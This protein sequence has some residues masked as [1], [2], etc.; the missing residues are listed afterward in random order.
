[1]G[2][3]AKEVTTRG[4][5]TLVHAAIILDI[6]ENNSFETVEGPFAY[7]R[8][9]GFA[10]QIIDGKYIYEIK[11]FGGS[12][13]PITQLQKYL[14]VNADLVPG[15]FLLEGSLKIAHSQV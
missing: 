10:D 15:I 8:G 7:V 13:S 4:F 9:A 2:L 3:L 11:P 14:K 12:K 6:R 1:M 5:G